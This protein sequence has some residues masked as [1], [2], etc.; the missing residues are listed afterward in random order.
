MF[1]ETEKVCREHANNFSLAFS[2]LFFLTEATGVRPWTFV[3]LKNTN[4]VTYDEVYRRRRWI[5]GL[6]MS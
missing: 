4:M 3:T 1:L 6:S 2:D 5:E